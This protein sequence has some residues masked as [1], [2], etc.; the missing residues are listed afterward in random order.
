MA[1]PREHREFKRL[2][3]RLG[4]KVADVFTY[5]DSV[6]I[7]YWCKGQEYTK[8]VPRKMAI[9]VFKDGL[10]FYGEAVCNYRDQYNKKIA[11]RVA[12]GRALKAA[13]EDIAAFRVDVK[14]V[15]NSKV[16]GEWL[17]Y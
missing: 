8:L 15:H 16:V 13:V 5:N 12:V 2:L 3:G 11:Y 14:D 7:D 4:D 6:R 10:C 9:V 1:I 17:K